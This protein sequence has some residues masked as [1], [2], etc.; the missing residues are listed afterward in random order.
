M[1]HLIRQLE[2]GQPL[3]QAQ[4]RAAFERLLRGEAGDDDIAAFLL[5]LKA[6]GERESEIIGAAQAMRDAMRR[7]E[8]P[9]DAMDVCGT[10]GDA[11]GTYNISTTV[12]FVLA[13]CGVPVVKHGN[14]AVSSKAGSTDVLAALGVGITGDTD[15]LRRCLDEAG[16]CYLAAPHFHPGMRHVAPVRAKLKTRTIF[17]LLG[18]LCNPAGVRFQLLGVYDAALTQT[19]AR[20]LQALGSE[21]AAVVHGEDGLDEL[22]ICGPSQV[23]QLLDGDVLSYEMKPQQAGLPEHPFSELLGGDAPH[24]ADALRRVLEG[25]AGAYRDAV[26]LN[27]AAA[28]IVADRADDPES[29]VAL[30]AE[31]IDSGRAREVLAKLVEYCQP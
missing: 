18:P 9:A 4:A 1:K 13:G 14:R 21:A 2:S 16:L 20:A 8:A 5:A 17:N 30:A 22:S 3:S 11:K 10:G 19:L 26:L 6:N 31:A 12:A 29:G 15:T 28:L 27:T 24:N 7:F 23:S 25:E